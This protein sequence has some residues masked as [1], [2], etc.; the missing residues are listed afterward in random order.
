MQCWEPLGEH[1]TQ[2]FYL[3]NVVPRVPIKTTLS[4]IFS[5][6]VLSGASKTTLHN[7]LPVQ[8]CPM[9]CDSWD[10]I[11]QMKN[12][13]QRCLISYKQHCAR[14]NPEQMLSY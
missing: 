5:H 14:K 12:L 9:R 1:C 13:V 8:C 3:C 2:G 4:R 6:A 10:N 7:I 11:A